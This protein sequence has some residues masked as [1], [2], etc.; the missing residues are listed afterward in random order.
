LNIT[1]T[2]NVVVPTANSLIIVQKIPGAWLAQIKY[3]GHALISQYPE[4]SI[5]YR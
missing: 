2:D 3:A 4:H 5:E 1:G